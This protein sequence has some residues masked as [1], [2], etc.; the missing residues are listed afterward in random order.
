MVWLEAAS[1]GSTGFILA[2]LVLL[3]RHWSRLPE[4]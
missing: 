2:A 1:W 4:L 3:L